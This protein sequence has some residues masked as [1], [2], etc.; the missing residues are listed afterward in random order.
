MTSA[1]GVDGGGVV[2][3]RRR[4]RN[5]RRALQ[6][7]PPPV[8]VKAAALEPLSYGHQM[9]HVT[10]LIQDSRAGLQAAAVANDLSGIV[11]WKA[12]GAAI[13]ALAKRLQLGKNMQLD[14]TEFVRRAER[15]LGVALRAAQARGEISTKSSAARNRRARERGDITSVL[16]GIRDIARDFFDNSHRGS[17]ISAVTDGI[18]DSQFE[19]ALIAARAEGNLSRANVARK[20][21]ALVLGTDDHTD[22]RSEAATGT[23]SKKRLT[24]HDSTEILT[25]ISGMLTGVVESL[26]F[27]DPN[28]VDAES[29]HLVI[30][31]IR[32][33]I[34]KIRS[35]LKEIT[36]G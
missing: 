21:R 34:G 36:N 12:K 1:T 31:S 9:A 26:P 25:N 33:S 3:P 6:I 30:N 5:A 28:D 20:A 24:K 27:I 16:P 13:E 15:S 35:L 2:V 19:Q 10:H 22:D 18:S 17:S 8:D 7:L 29:N 14:A 23:G 32:Q 4:E 11:E